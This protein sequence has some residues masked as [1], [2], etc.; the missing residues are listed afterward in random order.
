MSK[1][2]E[3]V[4]KVIV[5]NYIEKHENSLMKKDLAE[6]M[7]VSKS[8]LTE[9]FR[10]DSKTVVDF[11]VIESYCKATNEKVITMLGSVLEELL[12]Q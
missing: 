7:D 8:Y 10:V 11:D 6:R 2:N 3:I 4:R 9:L 1:T 12:K 5:K